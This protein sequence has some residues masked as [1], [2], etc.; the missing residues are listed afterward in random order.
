MQLNIKFSWS[1]LALDFS[2]Q[3]SKMAEGVHDSVSYIT[4]FPEVQV[5][6]TEEQ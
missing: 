4:K 6:D 5:C 2:L 3:E 1:R